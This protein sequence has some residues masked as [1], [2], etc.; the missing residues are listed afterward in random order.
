M[1][2][3][4]E[5]QIPCDFTYVQNLMNKINEQ[6]KQTNRDREQTDASQRQTGVELRSW[7]KRAEGLR[8]TTGSYK[9]VTR[10]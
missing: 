10:I 1:K 4:K 2:S 9:I 8:S 6:T 3:V 7:V 5:R